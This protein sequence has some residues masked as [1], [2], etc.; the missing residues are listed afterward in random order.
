MRGR[1][2]CCVCAAVLAL[3]P[4]AY[5]ATA[6][7]VQAAEVLLTII[8]KSPVVVRAIE[9]ELGAAAAGVLLGKSAAD[10]GKFAVSNNK[11]AAK[12]AGSLSTSD[13]LEW[14]GAVNTL[15][16]SEFNSLAMSGLHTQP[17]STINSG[18]NVTSLFTYRDALI[19]TEPPPAASEDFHRWLRPPQDIN[20]TISITPLGDI[21]LNPKL[22]A[23][24][25]TFGK[26][27]LQIEIESIP[28]GKLAAGAGATAAAKACGQECI[29]EMRQR[30]RKL[31]GEAPDIPQ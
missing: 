14:A 6:Q 8:G 18:T 7:E 1:W 16:L 10:V 19:N 21:N 3:I 12:V 26:T 20:R 31:M 11:I 2:L 13:K 9:T 27:R 17:E 28:A 25:M 4:G 29:D 24:L 22:E 23:P 15:R 5:S 30:W